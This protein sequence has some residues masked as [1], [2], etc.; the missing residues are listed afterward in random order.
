MRIKINAKNRYKIETEIEKVQKRSRVRLLEFEGIEKAISKIYAVAPCKKSLAGVVIS[1]CPGAF[2]APSS[3]KYP[4]IATIAVL[5][6]DGKG[7][8]TLID[9]KRDYVTNNIITVENIPDSGKFK[10]FLYDDF[11]K[12]ISEMDLSE[13]NKI[14]VYPRITTAYEL[15]GLTSASDYHDI[16][17]SVGVTGRIGICNAVA[18]NRHG[19]FSGIQI[20]FLPY[21]S[22]RM[23]V[24]TDCIPVPGYYKHVGTVSGHSLCLY[25]P[26]FSDVQSAM[27][28]AE[29]TPYRFELYRAGDAGFLCKAVPEH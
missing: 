17:I 5:R 18:C 12:Q 7:G 28:E 15:E 27:V 3:Y 1:V 8:A 2:K 6:F 22:V 23:H 13:D 21:T 11:I 10:D 16:T 20:K 26:G 9:I 4:A 24:I 19:D 14:P 25:I 29:G